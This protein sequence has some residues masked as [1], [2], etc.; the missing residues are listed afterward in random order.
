[1]TYCISGEPLPFRDFK[2]HNRSIWTD[3]KETQVIRAIELE[4]Q[5]LDK[6]IIGGAIKLD[7]VFNFDVS[8]GRTRKITH[9]HTERPSIEDLIRYVN[10]LARDRLYIPENVVS[11]TATKR[12]ST[13]PCTEFK[14]EKV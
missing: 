1:M 2:I 11:V 8:K 3:Y 10:V 12:F 7:I 4:N 14:V 6:P 9:H 13:K 5:H